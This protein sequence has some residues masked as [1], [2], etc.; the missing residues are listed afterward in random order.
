M[1]LINCRAQPLRLDEFGDDD[2]PS[3]AILSHTWEAGEVTFQDFS[4]IQLRSTKNGWKKLEGAC[5][6]SIESGFDYL[7]MDTCCIDKQNTAE[8]A[9]SINSMFQWYSEADLCLAYISDY[10]AVSA[11]SETLARSRWFER[12][13]TL[14]ELIAPKFVSFYDKEWRLF[15][16]RSSMLA[17]L[18]AITN[19]GAEVLS[20]PEDVDLRDMLD[21]IP[22]ARR[23]SWAAK[24]KTTK[25]EDLAYCLLGIFGVNMPML[26]GE[27]AAAF[28]RLQEEIIKNSNDLTLFAW[29]SQDGNT[30]E[31]RGILASSPSEFILAS[32]LEA[33]NDAKFNPDYTMSNKGLRIQTML[34]PTNTDQVIMPLHCRYKSDPSKEVGVVLKHQGASLY[35]RA[36]PN[37]LGQINSS[38]ATSAGGSNIFISKRVKNSVG[39][40]LQAVHRNAFHIKFDFRPQKSVQLLYTAPSELW[41]AENSM[42]ITSGLRNF[43]AYHRFL[44]S[45]PQPGQFVFACGISEQNG[46]WVHVDDE[47]SPLYRAA[48]ADNLRSV[49]EIG[50]GMGLRNGKQDL[51]T[52]A[53]GSSVW[54]FRFGTAKLTCSRQDVRGEPGIVVTLKVERNNP[55][56]TH[57]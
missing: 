4:N 13:W 1:R 46:P 38:T 18:S 37:L 33:I 43:T 35:A 20:P 12:G 31:Y 9:E 49:T 2:R 34:Y 27:G 30:A 57:F 47:L 29:T 25:K 24:R 23:M 14:Q 40:K 44:I 8:L 28:T 52:R 45:G 48:L 7:W 16:A 3:F 53:M 50:K 6:I 56:I 55:T 22:V 21:D 42:F 11:D 26:Y 5:R 32:N 19:I 51:M 17:E 41:D 54:K 39:K 10:D 36:R 15:G